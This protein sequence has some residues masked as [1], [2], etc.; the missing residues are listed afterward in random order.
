MKVMVVV[1]A[2]SLSFKKK[3]QKHRLTN[4]L[5]TFPSQ[6]ILHSPATQSLQLTASRT[7]S[8]KS[9]GLLN[10]FILLQRRGT[11]SGFNLLPLV[12]PIRGPSSS[13]PCVHHK[14][15][16]S[17]GSGRHAQM[18]HT[19][20]EKTGS[21]M[22]HR[23]Q[24]RWRGREGAAKAGRAWTGPAEEAEALKASQSRVSAPESRGCKRSLAEG[25]RS[26]RPHHRRAVS[27]SSSPTNLKKVEPHLA[28]QRNRRGW[29]ARCGPRARVCQPLL[30]RKGLRPPNNSK[31]TS[32]PGWIIQGKG[33][34][35]LANC[36]GK[37]HRFFLS[38]DFKRFSQCNNDA[39]LC[40]SGY[41]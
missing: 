23:N 7:P 28:L 13:F 39:S 35:G 41:N 33:T 8:D 9:A 22:A 29:W 12:L 1:L 11:G 4:Y 36:V 30:W 20:L 40:L 25:Q 31:P 2:S 19:S 38:K 37:P 3:K 10:T 21:E 27:S 18:V 16:G 34:E 26:G 24:P 6:H 5:P 14:W 15:P 32:S 17:K